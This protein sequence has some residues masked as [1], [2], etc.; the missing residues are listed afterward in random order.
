MLSPLGI[1]S[2]LA[3]STET[4]IGSS[5]QLVRARL[6]SVT[7]R[8]TFNA[9][10]T[11]GSE[12][13]VYYSPDGNNFDSVAYATMSLAVSAGS[14]IQQTASVIVPEHGYLLFKVKNLSTSYTL[15]ANKLW[16]SIQSWPNDSVQSHGETGG[17]L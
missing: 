14:T 7:L 1:I 17:S 15:T 3:A 11:L 16:Y 9:S 4:Q 12:V 13:N 10:A 8:C 2:S 5:I 6:L